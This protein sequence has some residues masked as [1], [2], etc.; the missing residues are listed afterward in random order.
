M[1]ADLLGPTFA[2]N[3]D[4]FRCWNDDFEGTYSTWMTGSTEAIEAEG[5][6][7]WVQCDEC[8]VW[9]VCPKNVSLEKFEEGFVCGD[10]GIGEYYGTNKK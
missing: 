4:V 1:A 6:F 5:A 9:L 3:C 7:N 8:N 10:E 2:R